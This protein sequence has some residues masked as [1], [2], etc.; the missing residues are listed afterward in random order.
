ML[1]KNEIA[2]LRKVSTNLHAILDQA[3]M[4]SGT[5]YPE[6]LRSYR[7]A[8]QK[9]I[10]DTQAVLDRIKLPPTTGKKGTVVAAGQDEQPDDLDL[11]EPDEAA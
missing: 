11:D 5:L 10:R 4:A 8:I 6:N 1:T 7:D 9:L 2:R 3:H